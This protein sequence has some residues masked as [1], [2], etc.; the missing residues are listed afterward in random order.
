M[1]IGNFQDIGVQFANYVKSI[2]Y[3]VSFAKPNEF[4]DW[5][6][7]LDTQIENNIIY[8]GRIILQDAGVY[9]I[10]W[11][12]TFINIPVARQN[13]LY[14]TRF[15]NQTNS[16]VVAGSEMNFGIPI[17][18]NSEVENMMLINVQPTM[19]GSFVNSSKTILKM[20]VSN[21]LNVDQLSQM[22]VNLII[23]KIV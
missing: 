11:S 16:E 6:P 8:D 18:Q 17:G 4:T 1:A 23:I 20:Q 13:N 15:F 19:N 7:E 21:E 12:T 3:K 5:L 14:K 22:S 9:M 2:D 10:Q